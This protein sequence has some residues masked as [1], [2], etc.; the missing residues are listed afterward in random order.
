VA[1]GMLANT[2]AQRVLMGPAPGAEVAA[3]RGIVTDLMR[4]P[5]VNRYLSGMMSGLA[6]G[7]ELPGPAH[8]LLG[9]RVPDL[10][11]ITVDGQVRLA[12]LLRRGRGLLL[13]FGDQPALVGVVHRWS[14][15]VDHVLAKTADAPI[16]DR[17]PTR[18]RPPLG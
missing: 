17:L 13:E 5:E 9:N 8:P 1:E 4:L 16:A 3:L 6:F 18:A 15:R 2:L 11:L 7:Y 12:E 14:A 10:D